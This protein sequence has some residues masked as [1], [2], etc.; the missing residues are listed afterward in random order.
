MSSKKQKPERTYHVSTLDKALSVLEHLESAA[1]PLSLNDIAAGSGTQ[2]LAVFRILSTLESRGYVRRLE[3][4][5]YQATTRRRPLVGYMA[6]LTGNAFRED[7]RRSLEAAARA[8]R[9]DLMVLDNA[10]DD[11]ELCIRNAQRLVSTRADAVIFFEPHEAIG[12]AIADQFFQARVPFITV[13]IGIESGV[14]F[15]ANNYQA[16]KLAGQALAQFA[17]A[18]WKGQFDYAVLIESTLS[19]QRVQAR[20]SGALAALREKVGE[21]PDDRVL[22]CD[23]RGNAAESYKAVRKLL[24]GKVAKRRLLVSAFND[25]SALG[26]L[27]AVRELG[28]EQQVAVV[29]Q[30]G[31]REVWPELLNPASRLIA[32]V[33]YFPE[34]YGKGL[35][36]LALAVLARQTLPPAVYA[37]HAL[38]TRQNLLRYYPDAAEIK[39][40]ASSIAT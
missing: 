14:Y 3:D 33:A 40:T 24:T 34:K 21:I 12:H 30:N 29:G 25:L 11:A 26:C 9:V 37:E 8:A 17:T 36:E 5:R 18:E 35:V 27:K 15:G 28:L 2:R 16:G 38:V 39:L 19:V 13:E 10:E 22:R 23:G 4:K 20:V 7:V 32:S 6:P 1:E 31:S